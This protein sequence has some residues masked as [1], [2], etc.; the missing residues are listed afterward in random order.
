M[1]ERS[2]IRKYCAFSRSLLFDDID[3][4]KLTSHRGGGGGI[5]ASDNLSRKSFELS[6]DKHY[7]QQTQHT[8]VECQDEFDIVYRPLD[9]D[10]MFSYI[11]Y[12]YGL[13]TDNP[14]TNYQHIP[15]TSTVKPGLSVSISNLSGNSSSESSHQASLHRNHGN[16][17]FSNST[18]K[19]KDHRSESISSVS[20]SIKS[21]KNTFFGNISSSKN[22]S[23][24]IS[25]LKTAS[26]GSK[27]S[28]TKQ[29]EEAEDFDD[30]NDNDNNI[31]LELQQEDT[32]SQTSMDIS[33][34]I[35]LTSQ[36]NESILSRPK[37]VN[38]AVSISST[39]YSAANATSK[40]TYSLSLSSNNTVSSD[41]LIQ[42]QS[43]TQISAS[44]HAQ[45][46]QL[47]RNIKIKIDGVKIYA[48]T[49]NENV[50]A[51]VKV[52]DLD[53]IQGNKNKPK[54][55]EAKKSSL[56]S[57]EDILVR[58][59][60]SV[61]DFESKDGLVEVMLD[62][63]KFDIDI[64]TIN[65]LVELIDDLSDNFI[66]T[67][68]DL[69]PKDLLP[70]NVFLRNCRF[71]LRDEPN[72]PIENNPKLIDMTIEKLK[73][74]RLPNN[75]LLIK[76]SLIPNKS[77]EIGTFSKKAVK[78]QTNFTS[79]GSVLQNLESLVKFQNDFELDKRVGHM[80]SDKYASL[81]Y[82]LRKS[83]ED[84]SQLRMQFEQ[85]KT[86]HANEKSNLIMKLKLSHMQSEE[87]KKTIK[88]LQAAK[89]DVQNGDFV[90]TDKNDT[91]L[92]QLKLERK[93][94]ECL[95]K[96]FE[97]ENESLKAKLQK[98]EDHIVVLNI[99]RQCLMKN[100]NKNK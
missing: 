71:R 20:S 33:T 76:E 72:T 11:K 82:M 16:K 24:L 48:Q 3:N 52:D 95:L 4:N 8:H 68:P 86:M 93:Q 36:F 46:V 38:A 39:G 41:S 75:Q 37:S 12:V 78:M 18:E 31:L 99:E 27:S 34:P 28:S 45:T 87:L 54:D 6:S 56:S 97:E 47:T 88:D 30:D 80:K 65:G 83:K 77:N 63:F 1:N 60:K 58:Y 57:N 15:S 53:I 90:L 73:L 26:I 100:I 66:M 2:Y 10:F 92:D 59:K 91:L 13:S 44:Q 22:A 7:Q 96:Q 94:F 61:D 81:V 51:L 74:S 35:L 49:Q 50:L 29:I 17:I 32:I 85:E 84:N 55:A 14:N 19:E 69:T 64:A 5:D 67:D 40:A 89:G 21:H 9:R 79:S 98:S 42:N 43:A 70:L 62:E 25:S 23:T